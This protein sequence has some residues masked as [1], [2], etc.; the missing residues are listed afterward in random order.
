MAA[1]MARRLW[2]LLTR[3]G[4]RPRGG[5]ISN[6]SPRRSFTTEKRNRNLLY[7]YAREGYSALPQLDIERFC[8]CP[9]EAAHAL[10]LRKGE[11]RSADLPAIISTWQELRQ[12]QEQIRSLEE[13]KAA[14]TE[15]V[16]ALLANQDSGEVQQDPKYQ[17]LRAR[18]REIRKELVHLYPREAQLEEQFYLQ[19]LKLPN[20]THPDVPVGDESQARVLH[21]VGDKPGACPTCLATGPITCAG[22]EPSCSTAWSTSHSTSFSAGASPP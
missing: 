11:L 12:L 22:L 21:M 6:D 17:G 4:F 10:E 1:S 8:A 13:E 14:V 5:C 15:A 18:G 19:A 2:P 3:R 7:E 20:Q 16:R 9:E